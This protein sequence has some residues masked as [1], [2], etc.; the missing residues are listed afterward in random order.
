MVKKSAS[1]SKA[2]SGA[3]G[4]TTVTETLCERFIKDNGEVISGFTLTITGREQGN[5]KVR[6]CRGPV[7]VLVVLDREIGGA[8]RV[9]ADA[10]DVT[11]LGLDISLQ[12]FTSLAP[13]QNYVLTWVIDGP[14]DD[15]QLVSELAL[16]GTVHYRHLKRRR[17]GVMNAEMLLIKV[18]PT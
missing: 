10:T 17:P 4:D 3:M 16:D 2:K 5:L 14:A 18:R 7:R 11:D 1:K 6:A 15:W 13:G 12:V 9:V 8:R